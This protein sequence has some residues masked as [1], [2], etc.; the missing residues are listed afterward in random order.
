MRRHVVRRVGQRPAEMAGLRI[1]AEQHQGHAG[2]VPDVFETVLREAHVQRADRRDERI[3]CC[4]QVHSS[5]E[6]S[7]SISNGVWRRR[8]R[9]CAQ[10]AGRQAE[11]AVPVALDLEGYVDTGGGGGAARNPRAGRRMNAPLR[12]RLG[13]GVR[14]SGKRSGMVLAEFAGARAEAAVPVALDPE[15]YVDTG[16]GGGAA[17]NPRAGRRMT[18][19]CGRGSERACGSVRSAQAWCSRSSRAI[20]PRPPYQSRSIS[21]ATSILAAFANSSASSPMSEAFQDDGAAALPDRDLQ[22]LLL[23]DLRRARQ[24]ARRARR[25]AA[26]DCPCR[27]APSAPARCHSASLTSVSSSTASI[28]DHGPHVLGRQPLRRPSAQTLAETLE[29]R[30]PASSDRPHARVRRIS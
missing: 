26:A 24:S 9:R 15:G 8:G 4:D 27:T 2:H 11:A 28:V 13:T 14:L 23:P 16:G 5:R 17:R 21:K 3:Q 29:R 6:L 12:S 22:V 7:L 1:V 30:P 20:R 19:P 25:T 10:F 18:L